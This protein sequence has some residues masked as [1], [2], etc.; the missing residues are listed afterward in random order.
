LTVPAAGSTNWPAESTVWPTPPTALAEVSVTDEVRRGVPL[1][2]MVGVGESEDGQAEPGPHFERLGVDV[3]WLEAAGVTGRAGDVHAVPRPGSSPS[4]GWLVGVGSGRNCDYRLAGAA[5]VRAAGARADS[6]RDAGRRAWSSLQVALPSNIDAERVA[7]FALGAALGSYR[8]RISAED[9]SSPVSSI[10]LIGPDEPAMAQAVERAAVL[11]RATALTRDLTNMP[12][13]VKEPAWLAATAARL[14]ERMPGLTAR[15]RDEGWLA[16]HGFGGVLAVGGGSARPPRLIELEWRP[17][18]TAAVAHLVLIGKGITFDTGGISIKPAEG[19]HLMRTDMAG[20]AAVIAALLAICE[21]RL[22]L[23][24]TGLVPAAENHVSG[25]AYRPGDVVRHYDG[26]T[27][28]VHNTDAE[29]RMVLAD[30]IGYAVRTLRPDL[31]VDVAT[32]TGSVRIALGTRTGGVYATTDELAAQVIE[33]GERVGEAWWRLPLGY[34]VVDQVTGHADEVRSE[35]ADI[36]Q[37]P[38]GPGSIAAALFLREFTAGVPWVHLDIA[39]T[40]RAEKPYDEVSTGATGMSARTLVQL[41]G[42][43]ASPEPRTRR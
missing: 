28:E 10:A 7:S 30:S 15:I 27:S 2:V 31:L 9:R 39:G 38:P 12:S 6:D 23:R 20:G 8:F 25:S 18:G 13:D 40:A 37:T 29:G 4:L 11:A 36:L 42:A 43:M 19:L 41:A 24:V 17:G 22:P 16:E 35:V 33:S 32:L 14:A 3:S 1:A 21:L 26:R 34:D 5:L